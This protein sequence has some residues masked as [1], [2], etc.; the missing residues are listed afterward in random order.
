LRPG[1]ERHA[2]SLSEQNQHNESQHNTERRHEKTS[3]AR[4]KGDCKNGCTEDYTGAITNALGAA[5]V[6]AALRLSGA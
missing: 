1:P 6:G 4:D 5:A 3:A 2:K